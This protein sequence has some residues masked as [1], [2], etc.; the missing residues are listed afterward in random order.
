MLVLVQAA[1][2]V[3]QGEAPSVA[4]QLQRAAADGEVLLS[5]TL[6]ETVGGPSYPA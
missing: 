6:G 5:A 4:Q 2:P 3:A 1:R